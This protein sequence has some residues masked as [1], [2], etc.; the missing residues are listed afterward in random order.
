M[1]KVVALLLGS[2]LGWTGGGRAADLDGTARGRDLSRAL[3][4][5]RGQAF[6][7]HVEFLSDDLLEGRKTGARG[8]DTAALYVAAQLK[9]MGIPPAGKDESYFQPVPLS[10]GRLV[11]GEV[12]LVRSGSRAPL[13]ARVDYLQGGDPGRTESRVEAEVV[14]AGFGISAPELGYDD[15]AGLDVRGKIVAL[16]GNAPPRFPSEPRAHYSSSRLKAETAAARGAVGLLAFATAEDAA[17]VP[18][19]RVLQSDGPVLRWRH[20]DGRLEGDTPGLRGRAFLSPAGARRLFEGARRSLEEVHEDARRSTVKGFA[21]PAS[22]A[23]STRSE[24]RTIESS[25]VVGVLPGSDPALK[26]TYVVYSAHL[27]HVG[28]GQPVRGDRIYNGAY[29]NASGVAV[30]LEAARAFASLAQKPRRSILFLF[31]TAEEDGLLGSDYFAHY[32]TVA[33]RGLVA[34]VNVDMPVFLDP[35]ADLIAFGAQN[36]SLERD[37]ARAAEAAG[38]ALL[39]DPMPEENVFIRSDQYS[40]VRRG[41]PSVFLVPGFRVGGE[42][43]GSAFM[44]F[45]R[46]HYHMP[47]DD[48][49]LPMDLASAERFIR[50]NVLVGHAVAAAAQAP[51][52][53]PGNFFGRTFGPARRN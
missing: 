20:P 24:P 1:K 7:A 38:L 28:E 47:T 12:A 48:L 53:K 23:I 31:V 30:I 3:E 52:W 36:S 19:E 9:A 2:A 42:G 51:D 49:R 39:P 26:D 25:N 13:E 46:D 15:Y 45:L 35:L 14:F 43:G 33:A 32:P 11:A 4:E 41:I 40:F 18:W 16:L 21:L 10:E 6:R 50:A 37:V 8:Y 5:V 34:N 22:A 17:R 27:D 44:A 29:D